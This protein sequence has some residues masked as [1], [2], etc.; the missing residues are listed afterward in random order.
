[1][2]FSS[3]TNIVHLMLRQFAFTVDRSSWVCQYNPFLA[4]RGLT[5]WLILRVCVCLCMTV[6]HLIF[7]CAVITQESYFILDWD[8]IRPPTWVYFCYA[9]VGNTS[10]CCALVISRLRASCNFADIVKVKVKA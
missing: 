1:M 9:T 7:Q 10:S 4:G 6:V 8:P 5:F 3:N 2:Q